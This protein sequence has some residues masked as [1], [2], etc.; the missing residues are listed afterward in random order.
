LKTRILI[1]CFSLCICFGSVFAVSKTF[2]FQFLQKPGPYP[3]GLKVVD[4]YD[5]FHAYPSSP[6]NLSKPSVGD[7]ARPLQTLIWY[8]SLRSIGKPMTVGDYARLADTEIHFDEPHPEQN[9][10]RSLLK[11]S[12]EIP[13]WAV[14][15]AKLA[16]GHYPVLIY[17]PSG[18]SVSWENADLCEYLAS[19]GYVILASPSMGVSTRDMTD[20]LDGIN[21]Q[22]SDISFLI[23]YAKTLPDTDSSEVAVVS[24]S[25]GGASSLFAAARDP[26]IDALVSMDGS[27]RYYPG[28][29]RMA[30]DVHP[31]RMTI[32]LLFFTAENANFLEDLDKHHDG[33][34]ADI[35]GPSV[36]NAWIHGDLL[37]MNMLGMAHPEFSSMFQRRESAQRFAE[38]QV[39]DYGRDDA[40]TS[41]AWV[42]LYT[43]NFLN[44]YLKHDASAKTF[45]ERTPAENGVPKHFMGITFRPAQ[46]VSPAKPRFQKGKIEAGAIP[47]SAE[48]EISY[49]RHVH[50]RV[51]AAIGGELSHSQ[52][53]RAESRISCCS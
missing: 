42:A 1:A 26:R 12:S 29:V 22:A 19:H 6:K 23:T 5:R 36:L 15:D 10:W 31:E 27:M 53:P 49:G 9:R 35:V 11:T 32:P 45:L 14:R 43:L 20:D 17:A 48:A 38:N 39:A 2:S 3:I 40:N 33:P 24:W 21:A 34:S 50:Q 7:D 41:H 37:T 28:L 4:Q 44:A 18:S 25:W 13:L 47:V 30:G 16:K 8:P 52:L 51:G 46:K